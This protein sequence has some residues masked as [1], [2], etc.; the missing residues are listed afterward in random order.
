[1]VSSAAFPVVCRQL[2]T[3]FMHII[4]GRLGGCSVAFACYI[5]IMPIR[6]TCCTY[7]ANIAYTEQG[8]MNN[9]IT[10]ISM[11][12]ITFPYLKSIVGLFFTPGSTRSWIPSILVYNKINV[13][14]AIA[15]WCHQMETFS[16]LLA[17]CAGNSLVPGEFPGQRPVTRIFDVFLDLRL[18]N[19]WANN[20]EAGDLSHHRS[21][22]DVILMIDWII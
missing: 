1:M 20:R 12:V 4:F 19:R 7:L 3:V 10:W 16:A 9:Y 15:W 11:F 18:N 2:W 6:I 21:H 17:I 5:C 22:Y 14:I 8:R 13:T